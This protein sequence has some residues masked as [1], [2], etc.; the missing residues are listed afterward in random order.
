[1]AKYLSAMEISSSFSLLLSK[2]I[3]EDREFEID[4][5]L[6]MASACGLGPLGWS[7]GIEDGEGVD[8]CA[9]GKV[10]Q[11]GSRATG[12]MVSAEGLGVICNE[13]MIW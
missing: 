11:G 4:L 6:V 7:D 12:K 9:V 10:E 3:V 13:K 8:S 2:D 5:C 1:M